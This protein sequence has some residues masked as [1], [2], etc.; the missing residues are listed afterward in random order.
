MAKAGALNE[1]MEVK[2]EISTPVSDLEKIIEIY[3]LITLLLKHLNNAHLIMN[4]LFLLWKMMIRYH[5]Y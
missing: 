5:K 3:Y 2:G 4:N 1:K